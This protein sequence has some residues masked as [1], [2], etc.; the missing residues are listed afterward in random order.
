MHCTCTKRIFPLP[1]LNPR[2]LFPLRRGNFGSLA[3][4]K[5]YIAYFSLRTSGLKSYVTIVFLNPDFFQ[6]AEIS[7]TCVHLRQ[8]WD[9]LIF[10]W[11]FRT[12]WLKMEVLLAK[13]GSGGVILTPHNELFFYF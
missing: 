13:W 3:I 2:Q 10:A 9:Y 11:V 4:N 5:G 12:Y 8:I 6:D 7:A 1:L